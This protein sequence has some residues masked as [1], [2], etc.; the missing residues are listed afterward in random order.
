MNYRD[1]CYAVFDKQCVICESTENIE[2]HHV[3]GYA[4]REHPCNL[5]PLCS[6]CHARV[7]N[8]TEGYEEWTERLEMDREDDPNPMGTWPVTAHA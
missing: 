4:E 3:Y 5:R 8:G 1:I 7:H 2:V 6:A